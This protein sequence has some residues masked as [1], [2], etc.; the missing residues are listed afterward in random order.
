MIWPEM[1]YL[2]LDFCIHMPELGGTQ[3]S[4][5]RVARE[6]TSMDMMLGPF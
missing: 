3:L 5:L 2:S 4:M 6:G 1:V